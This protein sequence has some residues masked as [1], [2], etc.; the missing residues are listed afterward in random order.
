[1]INCNES[2]IKAQL[3]IICQSEKEFTVDFDVA[4]Q[5][6]GYDKKANAKRTLTSNFER[7][8][9]FSTE[10][11]KTPSGG[12]PSEI[13]LLTVDCFKQFCML[14][15]T[16]QGK[17]VRMWYL[18]I[19]KRYRES[20]TQPK[21]QLEI[22]QELINQMVV[23]ENEIESLK[24]EQKQIKAAQEEHAEKIQKVEAIQLQQANEI[25]GLKQQIEEF[26]ELVRNYQAGNLQQS[27]R[28]VLNE[29]VAKL[30][31]IVSIKKNKPIGQT[32]P[33]IW[34]SI[35]LKLRNSNIKFDLN[36]LHAHSKRHYEKQL[37]TWKDNGSPRGY[38]P[39]QET[40]VDILEKCNFLKEAIDATI[41]IS[42]T[43]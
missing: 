5:W 18:E 8:I 27:D 6:L 21:S 2:Q 28:N 10:M 16:E 35:G 26:N 22:L 43:I 33:R 15:Q 11:S 36:A 17:Q 20:I 23:K 1:M 37:Q 3:E 19:E 41:L 25:Q 42:A 29:L 13:I 24:V 38:K 4:W 14:A 9:D 30:G 40:K 7:N 31:K 34:E 39:K 32:I 12:R